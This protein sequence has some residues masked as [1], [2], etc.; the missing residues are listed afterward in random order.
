MRVALSVVGIWRGFQV[1][2]LLALLLPILLSVLIVAGEEDSMIHLL[3]PRKS[4]LFLPKKDVLNVVL[5]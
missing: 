2:C 3:C 5:V 4:K 1:Q